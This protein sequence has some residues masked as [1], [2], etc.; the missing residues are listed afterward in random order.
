MAQVSLI[1]GAKKIDRLIPNADEYLSNYHSDTGYLYH[2]YRLKSSPDRIVPEDLAVTLLMNSRVGCKAFKG[3]IDYGDKINLGRLPEKALEDT[4]LMERQ[5]VASL[6]AEVAKIPGFATSVATKL[7]HK[8]RPALIPV[9]DNQAI[10]GAYMYAAWPKKPARQDSNKDFDKICCA[11][12]WIHYDLN[13]SENAPAWSA[14]Q[15]ME[16]NRT[17]IHIFDSVWWI[18]FRTNQPVKP[19]GESS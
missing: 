14:L 3:L 8:K 7:L 10:F 1:L 5:Q 19:L 16:P 17:R 11:L 18:Y 12:E 9:L 13:R 15:G 4:S 6:I 2:G